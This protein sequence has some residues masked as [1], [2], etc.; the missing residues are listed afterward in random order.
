MFIAKAEQ[1]VSCRNELGEGPV[2]DDLKQELLWLDIKRCSIWAYNQTNGSRLL[3]DIAQ[4]I[5]SMAQREAGGMI[6]ALTT[7]IYLLSDNGEFEKL[8]TPVPSPRVRFNDGKCDPK[9]RFWAGTLNLFPG[10]DGIA[11]LYCVLPNLKTKLLL[12]GITISNGLAFS[13]DMKTFFYIDTPTGKIDAFDI[14]ECIDGFPELK[15]RRTAVVVD[16]GRYGFPDGMTIDDEGYLWV[17]HWGSG[18]VGRYDPS[19][20]ELTGQVFIPVKAATSCC[21][22]GK[23][24]KTLYI[25]SAREGM[26]PGEENYAGNVYSVLL[27]VSGAPSWRFGG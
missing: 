2:W 26:H 7:G 9:G 18:M 19:N 13:A 12:S 3:L 21:F 17:A 6:L 20:G 27:P 22:G 8:S 1:L 23:D 15:N 14:A 5:G 11:E 4:N 16:T 10:E 24:R 25:T